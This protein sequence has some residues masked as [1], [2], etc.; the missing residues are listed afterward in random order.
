MG[1][2]QNGSEHIFQTIAEA[3]CGLDAQLVLSMG[4]RDP[5]QIGDL[6]GHPVVVRYAPQLQILKRAAAVITHAGLNTTL[7]SLTEGVPLVAIPLGNDQPGVAA[8]IAYHQAGVVIPLRKLRVNRLRGAID[9][10]LRQEIYRSRARRLQAA[11]QEANGLEMA[12]DV[13]ENSLGLRGGL[14]AQ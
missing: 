6:P 11:I 10:V 3:C 14:R 12:T 1:T 7:E 9:A 2:L 8:R 5:A 4:G 13:I